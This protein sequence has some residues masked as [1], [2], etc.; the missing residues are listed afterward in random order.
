M[1]ETFFIKR[2][3]TSPAIRFALEPTSTNLTGALVRFQMRSRAGAQVLDAPALV[4]TATLAP[5]VQYNWLAADTL[6]AGQFE[7][8]FRVVYADGTI[9]TFPNSGFILVRIAEDVR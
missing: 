4:I 6:A 3:D 9:E 5:T 8:E 2:G 7:A 1:N